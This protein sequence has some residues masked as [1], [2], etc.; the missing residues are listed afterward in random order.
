MKNILSLSMITVI[1]VACNH[2][3]G[4]SQNDD[5]AFNTADSFVNFAK[6]IIVDNTAENNEPID[7]TGI[8][9]TQP[10]DQEP[11]EV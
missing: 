3:G 2:N 8:Q 11:T 1:L 5:P 10:E 7:L 6:N 9:A 4:N